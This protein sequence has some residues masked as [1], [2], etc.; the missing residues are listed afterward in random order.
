MKVANALRR[1]KF[2]KTGV[3]R[4][5]AEDVSVA[6]Q[7]GARRMRSQIWKGS[8]LG[9]VDVLEQDT[10]RVPLSYI[11]ISVSKPLS[12]FSPALLLVLG[13]KIRRR[14]EGGPGPGEAVT[15][16]CSK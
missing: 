6:L 3:F 16:S 13:R 12:A 9:A 14:R 7:A 2:C 5:L 10:S 15:V 11:C 8:P 1:L 4:H